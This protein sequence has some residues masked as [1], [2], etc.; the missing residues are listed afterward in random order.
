MVLNSSLH[1]LVLRPG[2]ASAGPH[3]PSK[4]PVRPLALLGQGHRGPQIVGVRALVE[5]GRGVGGQLQEMLD[6]R[7]VQHRR[8]TLGGMLGNV[9][10]ERGCSTLISFPSDKERYSYNRQLNE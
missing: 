7:V 10:K 8:V 3:P 6:G 1:F 5:G 4:P 9:G 2:L